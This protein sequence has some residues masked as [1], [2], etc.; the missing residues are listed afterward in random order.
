[1]RLLDCEQVHEVE[2]SNMLLC[3]VRT[4]RKVNCPIALDTVTMVNVVIAGQ[5]QHAH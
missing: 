4:R 1:V 2:M 3:T 5:F